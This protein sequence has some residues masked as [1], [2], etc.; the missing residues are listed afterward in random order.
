MPFYPRLFAAT[1]LSLWCLSAGAA[2][3]APLLPHKATYRLTLDG[4]RPSGQLEEMNGRID[5]EI[6]GDACAGYTTMTRQESESSSGEGGP[7]RQAVTSKGWEDG[8]GRSYRFLSTTEAGADAGAK[9]E[10]NVERQGREALKVTVTQP[11]PRTVELKGDI[12]LPT[13]HVVRVL[14]AAA[15]DERVFQ[16]KV[17]DGASD[18]AKVYDTLTVIGRPSTDEARLAAPARATLQGHTFY[19][20]TVSYFEEGGVERAPAYVMSFTLYDNGV[21][22]GLKIDYGRFALLGAMSAF[23]PLAPAGGCSR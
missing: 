17:Y 20:V 10:A 19:P 9:I 14:A 18:P 1:A 15:A 7:V 11:Q 22:G 16:A 6:T 5:Y 2:G 23:E 4:S 8:E 13:E 21:V 3:A 12:L